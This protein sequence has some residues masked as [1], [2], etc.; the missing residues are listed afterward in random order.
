MAQPDTQPS[1][2]RTYLRH[3]LHLRV[4]ALAGQA[5][6]YVIAARALHFSLPALPLSVLGCI[7]FGYTQ[8]A[9]ARR[10][11]RTRGPGLARLPRR[12]G[13]GE[14]SILLETGVDLV[15]LTLALYLTGG[16]SNPLVSLLLLPVTVATA[17]LRPALSWS[18]AVTAAGCYTTLMFVHQPFAMAHHGGGAFELHIW[19]MWYGFLLSALLVALFVARLGDTLRA[20]DEALAKA[21]EE[22]LRN[23]Q[24]LALGTLAAGTAHELGTPLSTMA[25]IA[26][27]LADECGGNDP[28]LADRLNVLR[29][30]IDRCKGI[31]SR[32]AVDAGAAVD[33]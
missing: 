29:S 4:V 33:L 8:I 31:L 1:L 26:S 15:S 10:C 20:H 16:S 30:Q 6:G 32:M 7:V 11:A 3:L 2:Y 25:V 13:V 27:D 23:E 24:W 9:L 28:D 14:K 17:T 5:L 18:V 19:G 12:A 22:S 21:R